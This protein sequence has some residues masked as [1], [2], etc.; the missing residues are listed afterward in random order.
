M[1]VR[2]GATLHFK[3]NKNIEKA[4]VLS[5]QWRI[6]T[7]LLYKLIS[8][9]SFTTSSSGL[10]LIILEYSYIL[11]LHSSWWRWFLL[12]DDA[13][14]HSLEE[15]IN[16]FIHLGAGVNMNSIHTRCKRLRHLLIHC[17]LS[18]QIKRFI[19]SILM[20]ES[21]LSRSILFPAI[22][23]QISPPTILRNS[24]TQTFTFWKLS[25]SV[26]SYT[27]TAPCASL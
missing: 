20:K 21:N 7:L 24:L 18:I 6:E 15:I 22:T 10:Q 26:I 14:C 23:R 25:T 1:L 12:L 4:S 13:G 19:Q 9:Q 8:S 16:T 2:G 17:P 3:L 5:G 27:S 11:S